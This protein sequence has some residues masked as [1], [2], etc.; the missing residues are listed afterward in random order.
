M[1]LIPIMGFSQLKHQT[2]SVGGG[3]TS[4]GVI[5]SV[6]Q[7]S[8]IGSNIVGK[9]IIIQGFVQP[10][11][12][13]YQVESIVNENF[14]VTVYPNPFEKEFQALFDKEYNKIAVIIRA[15]TGQIVFKKNYKNTNSIKVDLSGNT[16]QEIYVLSIYIDGKTFTAK[17]IK[18]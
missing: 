10:P 9:L 14:K 8:V 1:L 17:I 16:G 6:G 15:L 18:R 11:N 4:S 12:N 2:L 13:S 7:N 3:S 5:Y